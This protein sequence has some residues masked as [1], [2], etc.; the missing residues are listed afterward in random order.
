MLRNDPE[1]LKRVR[2]FVD[3][4]LTAGDSMGVLAALR[5]VYQPCRPVKDHSDDSTITTTGKDGG[6]KGGGAAKL[7][8]RQH[9]TQARSIGKTGNS[10]R[11]TKDSNKEGVSATQIL[12][13]QR[14]DT[15]TRLQQISPFKGKTGAVK[16][17]AITVHNGNVV[18]DVR[19]PP[20]AFR[21][22]CTHDRTHTPVTVTHICRIPSS[23]SSPLHL[24]LPL[25][26]QVKAQTLE[27]IEKRA[28]AAAA[29]GAAT[30][31]RDHAL[32][33]YAHEQAQESV[34]RQLR[35]L[36]L[37]LE[38]ETDPHFVDLYRQRKASLALRLSAPPPPPMLPFPP[39]APPAAVLTGHGLF[40]P[41]PASST[42][43]VTVEGMDDDSA[44]GEEGMGVGAGKL[45]A[46]GAGNGAR[47]GVEDGGGARGAGSEEEED[48]QEDEQEGVRTNLLTGRR[49]KDLEDLITGGGVGGEEEDEDEDEEDDEEGKE[50]EPDPP[51]MTEAEALAFVRGGHSPPAALTDGGKARGRRHREPAQRGGGGGRVSPNPTAPKKAREAGGPMLREPRPVGLARPPGR[52]GA[53][54]A[55]AAAPAPAGEEGV[56]PP[57]MSRR[58]AGLPP[59]AEVPSAAGAE[60]VDQASVKDRQPI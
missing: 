49:D 16:D 38:T 2:K 1:K 46:A 34:L 29:A 9:V 22:A 14:I 8:L 37:L 26:R 15:T 27:V 23:I 53:A 39:F 28:A 17:L 59:E 10:D 19:L 7:P 25:T 30:A 51:A 52:Q 57:R 11:F 3:E 24:L 45:T 50:K 55:P 4:A 42:S 21:G 5:D 6:G 35:E 54:R 41:P 31:A 44:A 43:S 56:S 60:A 20:L 47:C 32:T 58:Q 36:N 48:E 18:R 12:A 13:G 33:G 40:S